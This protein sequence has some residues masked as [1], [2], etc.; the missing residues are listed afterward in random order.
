MEEVHSF[1]SWLE[2]KNPIEESRPADT[3][4]FGDDV[5]IDNKSTHEPIS[6]PTDG[7][8]GDIVQSAYANLNVPTR[9]VP[10]TGSKK[11]TVKD[12]ALGCA[13]AVSLIFY[14]ATGY[15]I[16]P[17]KT[18][19]LSTL[20]LWNH[21]TT[22][23]DWERIDNWQKDSLPGDVILTSAGSVAGH[24]GIVV[25]GGKVISNSSG[26]FDGDRKGQIEM[27]YS[28]SGWSSVAKR[29]PTKTASFRY[30]GL[31]RKE[32]NGEGLA[33]TSSVSTNSRYD[34]KGTEV[35]VSGK[36]TA[37]AIVIDDYNKSAIKSNVNY[38]K[39]WDIS[40][41]TINTAKYKKESDSFDVYDKRRDFLH[42]ITTSERNNILQDGNDITS[43]PIGKLYN[44]IYVLARSNTPQGDVIPKVKSE[45]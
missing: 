37:D 25:D 8:I 39:Y 12:G 6:Q 19:Q 36:P 34:I 28:I 31:Y 24:T 11:D 27:N 17:N 32:W 44:Q 45:T 4:G 41:S 20:R 10:G 14:R 22:S 40:N 3:E 15:S 21:M 18:L 16:Y 43:T 29:N 42:K 35:E 1:D 9:S 30:K 7:P 2:N 26:G 38:Y 23:K 5:G 33:K 13:A